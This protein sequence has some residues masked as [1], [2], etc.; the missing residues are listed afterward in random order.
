MEELEIP[1][2]SPTMEE[3]ELAW[4]L[5]CDRASSE[6]LNALYDRLKPRSD[7][8]LESLDD[9]RLQ[10]PAL[11]KSIFPE[12]PG[13]AAIDDR[14]DFHAFADFNSAEWRQ[15]RNTG[16]GRTLVKDGEINHLHDD[17][18]A[19]ATA[20]AAVVRKV[21]HD[22]YKNEKHRNLKLI[23]E[24]TFK[25]KD[26]CGNFGNQPC[27]VRGTAFLIRVDLLLTAA[28]NL[29]D[30][31]GW[32][33]DEE[34][35]Y[36]FDHRSVGPNQWMQQNEANVY[37]GRKLSQGLFPDEDWILI[38]LDPVEKI[39]NSR[40]VVGREPLIL[41]KHTEHPRKGMKLYSMGFSLGIP[42]KIALIGN[43]VKQLDERLFAVNL[44]MFK[45]NSGS[46]TLRL[47]EREV[48]GMLVAGYN[49]FV[50]G[51]DNCI[52]LRKYDY[53][54]IAMGLGGERCLW[55]GLPLR[56]RIN[57]ILLAYQLPILE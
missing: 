34:L 31:N 19:T 15:F 42:L 8:K 45:G 49:D 26:Y 48:V 50:N 55:V 44:D 28:H 16:T 56:L 52:S 41:A 10:L 47:R 29:S 40:P 5:Y 46:P 23:I 54:D 20:I 32:I 22:E 14:M 39:G 7:E 38:H 2:T 53:L 37:T 36:V 17:V 57:E 35:V 51:P 12:T 30:E 13:M 6:E 21:R 25:G 4:E 3:F 27:I 18:E 11:I 24:D 43:Y 33:P 1:P 9:I